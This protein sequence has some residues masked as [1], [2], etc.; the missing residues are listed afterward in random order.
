MDLRE[1][2]RD[3][4]K[5]F[6]EGLRVQFA[7]KTFL[8]RNFHGIRYVKVYGECFNREILAGIFSMETPTLHE[9]IHSY[10]RS[11]IHAHT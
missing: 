4:T 6:R 2:T 11:Y 1:S 3:S 8:P 10:I 9:H 5:V 7:A